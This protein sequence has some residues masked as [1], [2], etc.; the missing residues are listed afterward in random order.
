M[1]YLRLALPAVL[2]GSLPGQHPGGSLTQSLFYKG[3]ANNIA[4]L[5][6]QA[7]SPKR[8]PRLFPARRVQGFI[9]RS[10]DYS[11]FPGPV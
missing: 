10:D 9:E 7:S 8:G 3:A 4:P 6:G 1:V 11:A 2:L 5:F